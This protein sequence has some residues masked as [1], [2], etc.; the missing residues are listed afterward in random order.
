MAKMLSKIS[1]LAHLKRILTGA[2]INIGDDS[3]A[4]QN[5]TVL[6]KYRLASAVI[7]V[8]TIAR[9]IAG[10]VNNEVTI[11]MHQALADKIIDLGIHGHTTCHPKNF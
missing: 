6:A 8:A 4:L 3:E 7:M 11:E 5:T 2:T 9:I 1:G 10:A